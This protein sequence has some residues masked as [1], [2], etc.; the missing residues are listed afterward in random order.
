MPGDSQTLGDYRPTPSCLVEQAETVLCVITESARAHATCAHK[1]FNCSS[2]WFI[3]QVRN[4]QFKSHTAAEQKFCI[5]HSCYS[6]RK[7]ISRNDIAD[8]S[9]CNLCGKKQRKPRGGKNKFIERSH[10]SARGNIKKDAVS[11]LKCARAAAK[12]ECQVVIVSCSK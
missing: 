3:Y 6:P 1:T 2:P 9:R 11:N 12:R 5:T 4:L 7:C 10:L 8:R